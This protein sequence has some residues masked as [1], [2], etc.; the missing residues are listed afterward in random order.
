MLIPGDRNRRPGLCQRVDCRIERVCR[1]QRK[2]HPFR[3]VNPEQRRRLLPAGIY[4]LPGAQGGLVPAA[5]IPGSRPHRTLYGAEYLGG[6]Q[7]RCRRVIE[8][9]HFAL[10]IKCRMV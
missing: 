10:L 5:A 9:N 2:N 1:I 8:I 3:L 7:Q 4:K 6:L